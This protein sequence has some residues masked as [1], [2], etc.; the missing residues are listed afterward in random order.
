MWLVILHG[1]NTRLYMCKIASNA[2]SLNVVPT[3]TTNWVRLGLQGLRG[4]PGLFGV[5]YKTNWVSG[6][7][8]V[9]DEV[10]EY[11]YK[12]YICI[13]SGTYDITDTTAWLEMV[14]LDQRKINFSSANLATDDI[15]W[16]EV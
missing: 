8:Y 2:V 1:G 6:N 13:K 11:N 9:T 12:L 5:D 16:E 4:Y 10:V 15:Y 14:S 3:N 7:S